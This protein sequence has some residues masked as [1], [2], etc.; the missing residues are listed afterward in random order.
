M[1]TKSIK[2]VKFNKIE[3]QELREAIAEAFLE[4]RQK[5]MRRE[6]L[7]QI[8]TVVAIVAMSA[9]ILSIILRK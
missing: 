1:K 8:M 9:I 5:Q 4:F 7:D 3:E 6:L 2:D